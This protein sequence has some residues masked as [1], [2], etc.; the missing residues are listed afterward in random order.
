VLPSLSGTSQ[1]EVPQKSENFVSV[2]SNT[3]PEKVEEA[4]L[5][6]TGRSVGESGAAQELRGGASERATAFRFQA[7]FFFTNEKGQ[8]FCDL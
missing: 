1:V 7:P 4:P 8:Q 5:E 2:S 6:V 3:R